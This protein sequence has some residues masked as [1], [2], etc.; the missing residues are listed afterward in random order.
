M[1]PTLN[2]FIIH[3]TF[4]VKQYTR[5]WGCKARWEITPGVTIPLKI[6][7]KEGK[8]EKYAIKYNNIRDV[9]I[10]NC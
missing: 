7:G 1:A 10:A 4:I 8:T 2:S 9:L 3:G 5:Y 6:Y